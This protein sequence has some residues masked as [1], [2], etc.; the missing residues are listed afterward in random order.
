MARVGHE[1]GLRKMITHKLIGGHLFSSLS[2]NRS[3]R[4]LELVT[5]LS[6]ITRG[7]ADRRGPSPPQRT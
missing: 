1:R 4:V 2:G 6:L 3:L 5:G 7:K